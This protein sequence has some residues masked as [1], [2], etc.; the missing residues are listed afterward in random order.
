MID[1]YPILVLNDLKADYLMGLSM[2]R[3]IWWLMTTVILLSTTTVAN[4]TTHANSNGMA[5]Y[6][7]ENSWASIT[8]SQGNE[9]VN[10]S[11]FSIFMEEGNH[12]LFVENMS[13]CQGIIPVTDDLPNLRPSPSDSF[14]SINFV[15]NHECDTSCS[16]AVVTGD[17]V[18]DSADVY[19][20]NVTESDL[21]IIESITASSA[22]D[23]QIHFQNSS[24]EYELNESFSLVVNTSIGDNEGRFINVG[25]TGRIIF[26]ITS[27]SPDTIWMMNLELHDTN[28][29]V[30]INKLDEFRG[31]G[32]VPY[33]LNIGQYQSLQIIES[34]NA[35]SEIDLNITYRYVYS[36]ISSSAFVE[37]SPGDRIHG[38]DNIK[39]VELLWNCSCNHISRF[40][41][42]THFDA[43]WGIDAPNL[44]PISALS[45]NSSVPLIATNGNAVDG[46][47]TIH[48]ND[49]RDILRVET[50]GWNDSIHRIEIIVE[51]DIYEMEVSIWEMDQDSWDI[52]SQASSTYSMNEIAVS[53]NVGRGTHFV[54]IDQ[55]N[56]SNFDFTDDG[57]INW[58]IRASTVVVEEG[59]EPW[60]PASEEVKDAAEI[61]YILM[62]LLLIV[63]FII[64]YIV[65]RR[66]KK[67]A[68]IFASKNNR[69]DWLKEKLDTGDFSQTELSRAIKA[70]ASLEWE[71][72]LE[73]WGEPDLRHYTS[74]IDFAM[75]SLDQRISENGYWPVLIGIRPLDCEWSVAGLRFES[76]NGEAWNIESVEPKLLYRNNEVFLDT[77]HNNSRFFLKIELSGEGESLDMHLSGI[78]DGQPM[79]SKPPSTVYRKSMLSEE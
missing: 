41:L 2:G 53:L 5:W 47:L 67:F 8:D 75:W 74:G 14:E 50:Y 44:K 32:T 62:G 18:N 66:E 72:S 3:W 13:R 52:I 37:L 15:T 40:N 6:D 24:A 31:I 26:K 49:Y 59:E 68:E 23:V 71:K 43:E 55:Y 60:F 33:S 29:T 42:Q 9:I 30:P 7:C 51:G 73:V 34:K 19:A 64:F 27:P 57:V 45:D 78:V 16:R 38:M 46:E 69:L 58:K 28:E 39:H 12:T 61:F 76:P 10:S 56:N 35:H 11:D 79:A 48:M 20:I 63:P 70:V 4:L 22:L 1:G 54:V 77:I 25:Q 17:L 21:L 65:I 36:D